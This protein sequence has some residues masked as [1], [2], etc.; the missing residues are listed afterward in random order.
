MG[1]GRPP[2]AAGTKSHTIM[3]DTGTMARGP[4]P[5]PG[6]VGDRSTLSW[7]QKIGKGLDGLGREA[8]RIYALSEAST[9]ATIMST[10]IKYVNAKGS[11]KDERGR[12]N[13]VYMS[14]LGPEMLEAY[15]RGHL[16]PEL[17]GKIK[18]EILQARAWQNLVRA[19][20]DAIAAEAGRLRRAPTGAEILLITKKAAS[21]K[22]YKDPDTGERIY[23]HNT[24]DDRG[25]QIVVGGVGKLEVRACNVLA[26][27][28]E[29]QIALG[30]VYDFENKRED[31]PAYDRF[32]KELARLL[33]SG[34]YGAFWW[35]YHRALYGGNPVDRAR[36]FASFMYAIEKAGFTLPMEWEITLT[37]SGPVPGA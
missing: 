26:G 9:G 21:L 3:I 30:D 33:T 16:N 18:R 10:Y 28:Y 4:S 15:L 27:R 6:S 35:E 25:L 22:D 8:N 20:D 23:F 24:P 14:P 17:R 11:A 36:V 32:R 19:L 5:T 2:G 13:R 1:A 12:G 37:V 31:Q 7:Y 29:L 34:Q